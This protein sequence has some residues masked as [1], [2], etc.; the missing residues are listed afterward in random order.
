MEG[1]ARNI[2]SS[3]KKPSKNVK[4]DA[5]DLLCYTVEHIC[6]RREKYSAMTE[7]QLEGNFVSFM[8]NQYNWNNC[9]SNN[10]FLKQIK[11]VN[12]GNPDVNY[13]CQEFEAFINVEISAEEI[14]DLVKPYILD[15]INAGYSNEQINK[16]LSCKDSYRSL[17]VSEQSL[18]DLYFLQ[19]CSMRDISSIA[20]IPLSSIARMLDVVKSKLKENYESR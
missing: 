13:D 12:E 16:I 10:S 4:E 9:T 14:P 11:M 17:N 3:K 5:S 18:Y 7:S 1:V 6:S 19:G 20:K 8:R 2:V 15:L